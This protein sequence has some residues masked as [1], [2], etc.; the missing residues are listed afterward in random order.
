MDLKFIIMVLQL[1]LCKNQA[2][3][4]NA[5]VKTLVV[6]VFLLRSTWRKRM[7]RDRSAIT[8][9]T[10]KIV[11]NSTKYNKYA[12]HIFTSTSVELRL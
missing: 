10:P 5:S 4:Q 7:P 2:K 6:Y 9:K 1:L 3:F 8:L 11:R 12:L